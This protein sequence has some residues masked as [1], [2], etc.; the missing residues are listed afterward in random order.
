MKILAISDTHGFHEQLQI[1]EGIDMII[2]AGDI[3]NSRGPVQNGFE[4][5]DFIEWYKKIPVKYK[6]LIPGNHDRLLESVYMADKA[7]MHHLWAAIP[8]D[9]DILVTHGPPKGMLDLAYD[10]ENNLEYWGDKALLRRVL[11]ID[12]TYHIFGH[13]HEN[14]DCYNKGIRTNEGSRTR[15]MNASCV[16]DGEFSRGLTSHG[17]IFDY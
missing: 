15:F 10:R 11:Q 17:I 12:P 4:F 6:V 13:I 1:P 2:H 3:S 16:T 7:E 5:L 8:D 14:K 9:T